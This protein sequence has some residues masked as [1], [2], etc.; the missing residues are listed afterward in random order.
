MS[1]ALALRYPPLAIPLDVKLALERLRLSELKQR[2]RSVPDA[3]KAPCGNAGVSTRVLGIPMAKPVLDEAEVLTLI[4]ERI[5]ARV[6]EHVR[7]NV[8]EACAI[9]G[10][11]DEIV[12]RPA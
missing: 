10:L 11:G 1:P 5:A 12:H 3:L 7:V 6:A 9:A 2:A 8:T 4:G